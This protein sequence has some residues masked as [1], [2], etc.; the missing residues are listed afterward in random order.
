VTWCVDFFIVGRVFGWLCFGWRGVGQRLFFF[1]SF[2][3]VQGV[4]VAR[5]VLAE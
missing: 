5:F 1:V 3:E 4:M 2:V